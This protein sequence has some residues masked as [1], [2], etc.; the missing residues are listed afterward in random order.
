MKIKSVLIFYNGYR[1]LM[2]S[3]YLNSRGYNVFNIIT[4]KFLNKDILKKT[5]KKNLKFIKKI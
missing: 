3:R 5:S 1:G 4:K 2:L